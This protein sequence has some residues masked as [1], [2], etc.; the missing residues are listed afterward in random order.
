MTTDSL[1]F[2]KRQFLITE[3]EVINATE[4]GSTWRTWH[5]TGRR[6]AALLLPIPVWFVRLIALLTPKDVTH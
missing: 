1:L 3:D 6:R 2:P 5:A 4:P